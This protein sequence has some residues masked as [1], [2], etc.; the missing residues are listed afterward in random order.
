M[1][2]IP[3]RFVINMINNKWILRNSI[4]WCLEEDTKMFVKRKENLLNIPIKEIKTDD[5]V[6]TKKHNEQTFVKVK[7]IIN[8]G[9]K[10]GLEIITK[11]GKTIICSEEHE[12]PVK[13]KTNNLLGNFIK[14]KFKKAKDLTFNDY[15]WVNGE[16]DVFKDVGKEEDYNKGFLIGFYIAE[17]SYIKRHYKTDNITKIVGLQFSCGSKDVDKGYF[18]YFN[19]YIYKTYT[20]KNDVRLHCFDKD[21]INLI[22][23]YVEGDL[24]DGKHLSQRCWNESLS[25]IKGI[26]DGFLAGD[27]HNDCKN[28]WVVGIKPNKNLKDDLIL[29][30]RL[31]GYDFRDNGI[32]K[33]NYG[34]QASWFTIRKSFDRKII[35]GMY[36]DKIDKIINLDKEIKTYDIEVEPIYTSYDKILPSTNKLVNKYNNLYFLSNGIWTHN[37]KPNKVPQAVLDRFCHSFEYVYFFT[38]INKNYYFNLQY[39]NSTEKKGNK[40]IK[41]N[42]WNINTESIKGK[43]PALFPKELV[44]EI[45]KSGCPKNGIVLDPFFG[46]GT[47][48]IV[49]QN[50][51][52]KWIGIELNESYCEEAVKHTKTIFKFF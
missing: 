26:V 35:K 14:L 42:V 48:G 49:A 33:T 40:R 12:L 11:S 23:N 16:I 34:T 52:I 46:M 18:N 2:C 50:L 20:Y 47:T 10:K 8:S 45:L 31:I 38:K 1:L 36:V 25:F 4:V 6:L 44:Y 9:Y 32:R 39:E 22:T 5:F 7:N 24:C 3:E 30:C 29:A 13:T 43:H 21:L 41:R 27:G 28:R 51:N 15:L 19:N 17:G 37:C